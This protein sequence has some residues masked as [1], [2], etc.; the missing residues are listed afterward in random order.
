MAL[1][2]QMNPHFIFNCLNS[3]QQYVL[4]KDFEG[5]NKFLSDFAGLI[6]KTLDTSSK[7]E[8]T[9]EEELEYISTYLRLERSRLEN[10]FS[11]NIVVDDEV[12]LAD[13][14][15]PPMILQPCLE[16]SIRHGIR[17][18]TDNLGK[19]NVH[20]SKDDAYL[21]CTIEDNGVGM[22]LAQEYK[23]LRHIEHHSKGMKLT[24]NRIE[25]LSLTSGKKANAVWEDILNG[26]GDVEGTR[27]SIQFPI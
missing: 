23:S 15:L 7:K 9:L 4:E 2:A 17:N 5:V 20:I 26:N 24:M 13:Y 3:I 27:V 14:Y 11:F 19:I 10:K 12:D 6:R 1:K 16:N 8:I 25:V 22:K 18:R 21:I